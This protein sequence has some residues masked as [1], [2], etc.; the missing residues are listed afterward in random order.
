MSGKYFSSLFA[1]FLFLASASACT[2]GPDFH[3]PKAPA[4]ESYTKE[5]PSETASSPGVPGGATQRV[6]KDMDLPGQW[7]TLFASPSLNALIEQ[8]IKANPTVPA[9]QAALRQAHESVAAQRGNYLPTVQ[10]GGTASRQKNATGTIAP[11]LSSNAAQY[12]LYTGQVG[13]SFT[14]DVFGNNRRQVESLEAQANYQRFQLEATYLTLASNVVAAAV[15]EAS[16]RAQIEATQRIVDIETRMLDITRQRLTLGYAPGLDLAAQESA[17]AQVLQTLPPLQKQL[18]LTRDQLTALMGR[19]P[20]DEPEERFD[21]AEIQLPQDLPV[22]LPS[23][24]VEQRPDVRAAEEQL[25][26]ACAQV[27]VA[28]SNMLPQI[29]LSGNM[30][31]T[32]TD[33]AQLFAPGN[34]YWTL[35]GSLSQTVFAGGTLLHKKRA[36]EAGL[37]QAAAQYRSTVLTAFQNVA[38]SLHALQS[39]ADAL[40][41]AVAAE[42]AAKKTLDLTRRQHESGYTNYLSLLSAEQAY[43]QA[44]IAL[45]QARAG[46]FADTAALFQSLGGGWWNRSDLVSVK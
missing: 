32:A 24:L 46:R 15:Q 27:G 41:A 13:V 18:A 4:I 43:H 17:L 28:L 37:D 42:R 22:G 20:C 2:V 16:L 9:A 1:T 19:F 11:T 8:A 3:R 31:T 38:D 25:H 23:K 26:S 40:V 30:G 14:P 35:A 39:D 44:A 7:W 29:V 36:A 33:I 5:S 6:V 34:G 45:V 10:A 12:N 21:L